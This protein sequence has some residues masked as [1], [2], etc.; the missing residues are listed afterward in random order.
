VG[1][2]NMPNDDKLKALLSDLGR[3]TLR[4]VRKCPKCG[5]YNGT[6]GLICKNRACDVVFKEGGEKRKMST[7]ACKL[8]TGT[9]TQVFSVRVRDKGPDYR[10]FVQLPVV[11]SSDADVLDSE[12]ALITQT[13]AL[14]FVDT[15]QRS[16]DASILKCHGQ[17]VQEE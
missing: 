17:A 15:C 5:T 3:A 6:R 16:F 12:A 1:P 9:T 13:S 10:G 4:G 7:E 8:I 14:C 11:Q 2:L